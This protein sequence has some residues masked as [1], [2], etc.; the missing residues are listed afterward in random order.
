M[1]VNV[2]IS[3]IA[4][5]RVAQ[6]T[7]KIELAHQRCSSSNHTGCLWLS[8][9]PFKSAVDLVITCCNTSYI[10][11]YTC[12][13]KWITWAK[14]G[15]S[16]I[17]RVITCLLS[18]MN[19]QGRNINL[20]IHLLS[21]RVL[22]LRSVKHLLWLIDGGSQLMDHDNFPY[23][24]SGLN[25]ITPYHH[26]STNNYHSVCELCMCIYE[27][28]YIYTSHS[29]HNTCDIIVTIDYRPITYQT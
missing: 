20:P 4:V 21:L 9:P 25:S 15:Q 12:T 1:M 5:Q 6:L 26:Q 28:V 10:K 7:K 22:R 8:P 24:M 11:M 3:G 2:L 17:S 16:I 23:L 14:Q 13:Y 29:I 27:Y 19:H 18:G